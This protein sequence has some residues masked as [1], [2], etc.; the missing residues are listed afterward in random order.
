[1]LA[2]TVW[3]LGAVA[4]RTAAAQSR[5]LDSYA[6][7]A[8]DELRARA[9]RLDRGDVGVNDGTL[10]LRTESRLI[11]P[12]SELGARI[13]RIADNARCRR[14]WAGNPAMAARGCPFA[15]PFV[16]PFAD[17]A[18]VEAACGYPSEFP[19][20]SQDPARDISVE[21]GITRILP[22][23]VYGHLLVRGGGPGQGTVVL[24]PG[25]YVFCGIQTGRGAVITADSTSSVYINGDL[26]LGSGSDI[27]PPPG[28]ASLANFLVAGATVRIA[29]E[30]SATLRVCAPNATLWIG[31]GATA[32]GRFVAGTIHVA[33]ISG[34]GLPSEPSTTSS[35]TVTT[36]TISTTET[37]TTSTTTTTTTTTTTAPP[38]C[39]DG[40]VNQPTEQCDD[41]NP[42]DDDCCS[43]A[44]LPVRDGQPCGDGSTCNG[45]QTCRR[46][47]CG[48]PT[49][50]E[51][52]R[53][54][55][56]YSAAL[57]TNFDEGTVS[58]VPITSDAVAAT[59][60]VGHGAWGVAI[61]PNG[62]E[63]WATAREVDQ[64]SVIDTTTNTVTSQIQV[65]HL[66]L[67]ITFSVDGGTAYIA[68]YRGRDLVVVDTASRTV[69]D[70]IRV[71][72]GATG[73]ALGPGGTRLYV[74]NYADDTISVI[75]PMSRKVL[76][77]LRAGRRPLEVAVDPLRGRVYVSNFGSH[78]VSVIGTVSA[79]VLKTIRVGNKPFGIAV[80]A[81]GARAYVTN[82]R[83]DTVSVIDTEACAVTDTIRVGQG[84]LGIGLDPRGTRA[85]VANANDGTIGIVDTA[86]A[87]MTQTFGTGRLPVA[88]GPFIGPLANTCARAAIVCSDVDPGTTDA[89]LTGGACQFASL[90]PTAAIAADL[91]ALAT[92]L[93]S[94]QARNVIGATQRETLVGLVDAANAEITPLSA[95][96][97][98][99]RL[100]IVRQRMRQVVRLVKR[101]T[102]RGTIRCG[103]GLDLL[104]LA[105][106][107]IADTASARPRR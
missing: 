52:A 37:T 2:L 62:R 39:G 78:S 44:C 30:A 79:R 20:C 105:F 53:C 5:D 15:G 73:V 63:A 31:P 98:R 94:E 51:M 34:G 92:G 14:M 9:L 26:T 90:T 58:V 16:A 84:P 56:P 6:L 43:I 87:S 33:L 82:A 100:A 10:F 54:L 25:R 107:T 45:D 47:V 29:R 65:G 70:H 35:T 103:A 42:V 61:H 22:P 46:G 68:T 19:A 28:S 11:A 36:S 12:N 71:G 57:I 59:V 83:S 50:A 77:T 85:Y 86:T 93:A 1:M 38:R 97:V 18:A 3:S 91:G 80:D 69:V 72:K 8:I 67:G 60:A 55:V 106:G 64:V 99:K 40:L 17:R 104:D 24:G 88:F 81:A 7:F 96:V 13:V 27:D 102:H 101:E 23:G 4:A 66:P 89:C 32:T 74:S 48:A 21:A 41:G 95:G 76:R 49:A 75:D